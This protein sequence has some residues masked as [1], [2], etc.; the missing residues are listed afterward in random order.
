MQQ[1][2]ATANFSNR[3]SFPTSLGGSNGSKGFN[4][5]SK[6][7]PSKSDGSLAQTRY[8]GGPRDNKKPNKTNGQRRYQPKCQL[9]DQLGHIAKY[10]PWL[11]FSEA[12][13]NCAST[14]KDTKWLIDSAASHNITGDLANLSVHSEYD[15]T[16]EVVIGDGSGLRVSHID[17]TF[18]SSIIDQLGNWFSLKD[19]G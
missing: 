15:G 6:G 2:I 9:Y 7:G 8:N 18:V 5:S 3:R 1:L 14:S 17:P 13:A 16:D 12:T 10:C 19:M 4:K 11:N